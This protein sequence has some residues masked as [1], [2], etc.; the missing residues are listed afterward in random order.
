MD[1][2]V[3]DK[4]D[5]ESYEK[6][7]EDIVIKMDAKNDLNCLDPENLSYNP[8]HLWE[9][10]ED[11]SDE[12]ITFIFK[13]FDLEKIKNYRTHDDYEWKIV[14]ETFQDFITK[15]PNNKLVF[16]NE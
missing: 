9:L 13:N 12:S 8:N 5:Y 4:K 14:L 6:F 11:Y 2:I 7:Y 15:F 3:I 1:K 16:E 10:L